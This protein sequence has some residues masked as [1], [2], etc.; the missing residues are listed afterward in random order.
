MLYN[1]KMIRLEP[2]NG[3][4]RHI[5][6]L[7]SVLGAFAV[8]NLYYNQALLELISVGVGISHVEANLITV[9]TQVGYALGLLFVIP[10]ADMVSARHIVITAYL[11]T[12]ASALVIASAYGV[13]MLWG[14][15]LVL[16]LC[17]IMPQLFIPM[18][19]L[20]S[21]PQNKSRNMGYVASGIMLGILSARVVSGYIGDWLGWRADGASLQCPSLSGMYQRPHL[22][23]LHQLRLLQTGGVGK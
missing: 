23:R 7:M 3:I 14:G 5:L 6:L 20:Y 18:A 10:L 11:L 19:T 13:W 12:A 15:S 1:K 22:H 17:S 21:R 16:G 8:A 4:P 9:I 2:N